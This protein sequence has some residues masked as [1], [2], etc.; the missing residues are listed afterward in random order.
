[1][2]PAASS[3]LLIA[4]AGLSVSDTHAAEARFE[5]R[6][7]VRHVAGERETPEAGEAVEVRAAIP[8]PGA[9][10]GTT[11][12]VPVVDQRQGRGTDDVVAVVT[13]TGAPVVDQR[14]GRGTDDVVAATPT[15]TP[16]MDQRQGRGTDDVVAVVTTTGAPVVD[17]R[18]GRGTDDAARATV[19]RAALVGQRRGRGTDDAARAAA[20]VGNTVI[21]TT[22]Q[23]VPAARV[24]DNTKTDHSSNIEF[25]TSKDPQWTQT[26]QP[27]ATVETKS[28]RRS[29]LV[30]IDAVNN[31]TPGADLETGE[32]VG[33]LPEGQKLRFAIYS[34][35][36]QAATAANMWT[37][38]GRAKR[39][40]GALW[41][42]ETGI[43]SWSAKAIEQAGSDDSPPGRIAGLVMDDSKVSRNRAAVQ[44]GQV[45]QIY[46]PAQS[47]MNGNVT[48]KVLWTSAPLP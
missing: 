41:S 13:A 46:G 10:P 31:A 1:M 20:I 8:V 40:D 22:P 48:R 7:T 39:H 47:A 2:K 36:A 26:M 19:T 21:M 25:G 16:V 6:R 45:V 3:C 37:A 27:M 24:E 44:P 15:G 42:D 11:P 32:W 38:P 17:Q 5:S 30:W 28:G 35:A 34:S 29:L 43:V 18:Q 23:S 12:A 9:T 4:L 14:Q 33:N